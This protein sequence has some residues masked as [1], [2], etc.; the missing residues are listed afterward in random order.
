MDRFV[1]RRD[2]SK[3]PKSTPYS[4]S[5]SL[6]DEIIIVSAWAI[7]TASDPWS[8]DKSSPLVTWSVAAVD[9]ATVSGLINK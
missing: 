4:L 1:L 9:C 6:V 5:H 7:L 2:S 3:M 8:L